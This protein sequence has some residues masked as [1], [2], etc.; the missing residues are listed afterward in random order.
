MCLQMPH[1]QSKYIKDVK[2]HYCFKFFVV[3]F[4]MARDDF[5]FG[6]RFKKIVGT[7]VL[8]SVIIFRNY[9]VA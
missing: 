3:F 8:E 4:E 6:D 7:H 9:P 1:F 5:K 2:E